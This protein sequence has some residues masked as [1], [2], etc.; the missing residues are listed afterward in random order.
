[1]PKPIKENLLNDSTLGSFPG[2]I[3]PMIRPIVTGNTKKRVNAA[4]RQIDAIDRPFIHVGSDGARFNDIIPRI[5]PINGPSGTN[6]EILRCDY[7]YCF[8]Q[9]SSKEYVIYKHFQKFNYEILPNLQQILYI[10]FLSICID[11]ARGGKNVRMPSGMGGLIRYFDEYR[12]K[13]AISPGTVIVLAI[14]VMVV[15]ILLHMFGSRT[16]GMLG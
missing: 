6:I 7:R 13:I 11:M 10:T 4:P 14:M 8:S 9:V 15:V 16:F 3:K 1:M 2:S 12:S 5:R